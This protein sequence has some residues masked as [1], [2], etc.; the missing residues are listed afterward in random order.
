ML[1]CWQKVPLPHHLTVISDRKSPPS[2]PNV[3]FVSLQPPSRVRQAM[4]QSNLVVLPCM[5]AKDGDMDGI[6]VVLM[7]AMA[8]GRPVITTALSGIP[9][10]IS[11]DVGWL[12]PPRDQEVFLQAIEQAKI[13]DERHKRGLLSRHKLIEK[14]HTQQHHAQSV[15]SI[16][17]AI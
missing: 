10:L 6:P 4:I 13:P 9:E 15:W 1:H 17:Q 8:M 11:P 14:Q 16:I 12:L 3:Q 2:S 7:E 5:P